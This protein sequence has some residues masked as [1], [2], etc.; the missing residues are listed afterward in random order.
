MMILLYVV[1]QYYWGSSEKE[2]ENSNKD[3]E[4]DLLVEGFAG[5]STKPS[6]RYQ[7]EINKI[8]YGD[9]SREYMDMIE[10]ELEV[11]KLP[12]PLDSIKPPP[13]NADETTKKELE[14]IRDS[15]KKITEKERKFIKDVDEDLLDLLKSFM[16]KE[17]IVY[18]GVMI[19][20]IL[21]DTA[22]ISLR[23]KK[24]FNRPRPYQIGRFHG[25]EIHPLKSS[26]TDTPSYPSGVA[27]Q[28][29]TVAHYVA[30]DNPNKKDAILKFAKEASYSRI[31]A[32]FNY[33]SDID[34]GEKAGEIL[35]KY[36]LE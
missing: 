18:D 9:M 29:Y 30:K 11:F 6:T 15:L 31:R 2:I 23:L 36:V 3:S 1:Y 21:K 14:E 33:K 26:N 34:A 27:L 22:I 25:I 12:L 35:H 17:K 8:K 32:G 5:S 20:E 10:D 13:K 4:I 16:E 19:S 24:L 28:I 7:E